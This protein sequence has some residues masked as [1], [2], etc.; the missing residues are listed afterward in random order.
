MRGSQ[1]MQK[2]AQL[3]GWEASLKVQ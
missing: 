2:I 3:L 1:N